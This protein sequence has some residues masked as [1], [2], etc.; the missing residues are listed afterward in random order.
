MSEPKDNMD[1]YRDEEGHHNHQRQDQEE[2]SQRSRMYMMGHEEEQNAIDS[3]VKTK[4]KPEITFA[5]SSYNMVMTSWLNILVLAAPVAILSYGLGWSDVVTFVFSLI[6]LAPLAERL[7]F[8]TEQLSLHTNE[9]IGGL[10]NATFGNAT[11]LI[12][13][14][15]ALQK[16]LFRLV[17]LSL[18]GS[19][20]SNLLLVL[21]TAFLFGGIKQPTQ[22]YNKISSQVNSTL[23][24][25]STMAI[26]Y[27]TIL[28][29]TGQCTKLGELGLSRAASFTLLGI[30]CAYLYFQLFTHRHVYDET[31][32]GEA[33]SEKSALQRQL[34]HKVADISTFS[35]M[36]VNHGT[37]A[38]HNEFKSDNEVKDKNSLSG[39]S[40]DEEEE[41]DVL[42]FYNGL[43]WLAIITVLIAVLSEAIS[44]SIESFSTSV[45]ISGVFLAAVILPIV[46]NAAEHAGAVVFAMKGKLDLTLGIAI[47]SSTQI[48]LCVVPILVILAWM[49]DLDLDL[50]FGPY[51]SLSVLLTVIAVTFAIKDG[52]SNW[53]IGLTLIGAY[54]IIAAG[55]I[56]HHNTNLDRR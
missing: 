56:A 5:T 1:I 23:L 26:L 30:Y 20:L 40:D 42:G 6:A 41:E 54:F 55:F 7:G 25:I 18:L 32:L 34:N 51:E 53:L 37:H 49:M 17:Q 39:V 13:S 46:G 21:G 19:I 27:P 45:G 14:I 3:P 10:L 4:G 8:V 36:K 24:I 44:S 52:E 29:N 22:T 38:T 31:P 33:M 11:E 35:P 48:A 47:G 2:M 15:T 43:I 12:V 28:Y 50:D 16:G 9:T